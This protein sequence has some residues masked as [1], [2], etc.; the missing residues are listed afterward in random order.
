MFNAYSHKGCQFECKLT[1]AFH[2]V[3]CIPWDYPVPPSVG[4]NVRI[5]NAGPGGNLSDFEGFM[6][7]ADSVR[8]CNCEPDCGEIS[9]ETQVQ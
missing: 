8:G 4:E 5:C 1:R 6:D 3:G 7:G 2:A 9:F